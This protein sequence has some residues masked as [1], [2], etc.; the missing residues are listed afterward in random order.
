MIRNLL[1]IFLAVIATTQV[2][3]AQIIASEDFDYNNGSNLGGASGGTG[4]GAN[5]ELLLG[6][7]QNVTEDTIRNF[8]TGKASGSL[9]N[10][11]VAGAGENFRYQRALSSAITDNGQTIWIAYTLEMS[12]SGGNVTNLVLVNTAETGSTANNDGLKIVIGRLF[13]GNLGIGS[14]FG[15]NQVQGVSAEQANWLVA[16]ITFTGDGSND[17]FRLF[18]NPDPAVEPQDE[19]ADAT[20]VG[21]IL[22][23]GFDGILI[24]SET[25]PPTAGTL[26][27]IYI[28]NSYNDILPTTAVDINKYLPVR[29]QFE[30]TADA[31]ISGNGDATEGWGGPW[32]LTKAPEQNVANEQITN[33]NILRVT[34]GN[35]LVM[36]GA[37]GE[38]RLS[39][40]LGQTYED[41]GLTYWLSFMAD[42]ENADGNDIMHVM[43][44]NNDSETMGA[45]GPGGQFLAV[46]KWDTPF[47]F[48]LGKFSGGFNKSPDNVV[49]GMDGAHWFVVKVETN[50]TSDPDSV[51]LWLNPDPAAG[52][53]EGEEAVKYAVSTLNDGWQGIGIKNGNG[54]NRS[55]IDDIYLALDFVD[56]VPDDLAEFTLPTPAFEKFDYTAG[57]GVSTNG[58]AE[59]GWSGPWEL[60]SGPDQNVVAE[61]VTNSNILKITEGNSLLMDANVGETRI[62]RPLESTYE[63]N[64]LTYWMSFFADFRNADGNGVMNVMLT[65]DD[66]GAGGPNGQLLAVGKW[67]TPFEFGLGKFDGGFDKSPDNVVTGVDGS[68]W[69][70]VRIETNGTDAVDTVRLYLNPDPDVV[71]QVGD[72][73]VKY[74]ATRLNGGWNSIGIKNGT[75][76]LLSRIDD[77]YL[78][79]SFNEVVPGDL[80][81]VAIPDPAF[82][83][84][85]YTAGNGLEGNGGME[86]GWAGPWELL[87]GPSQIVSDQPVTNIEI[88]RETSGNSL[89]MDANVGESRLNRPL[90]STYEDNG[91]TYWMGFFANFTNADGNGV[92]NVML[93]NETFGAG[94]PNGQLLAVGKWDTP[95]EFGLG[96]FDGGF[97][98]SPENVVTGEDGTHWFVVR[99]E[100]NGTDAADTIRL[101]LNPD[102]GSEPQVGEE[103]VTYVATRLN[104]GWNGIG[105]KN[106]TDMLLA[107]IDDIY[108]GTSFSEIVPGDLTNISSLFEAGATYEPF[109]YTESTDLA[110]N[111]DRSEGF[112]GPWVNSSGD[113]VSL[114]AGS[115]ETDFAIFEGNKANV[116]YTDQP[117][118]YD[119]PLSGP[120]M[121]D[122]STIWMSFL[123]DFEDVQKISTEG[124]LVLMNGMEEVIGFGR[125]SGFNRIGF[126]W[127]PDVFQFI[128]NTSSDDEHWV[129]VRIDMS[130]DANAET[131]YMWIDPDPTVQPSA[132][133]ADLV[134]DEN[135]TQRLAINDGFDGIR[136]KTSGG[137][138]FQMFVDEIRLGFSFGDVSKLEEEIPADLVAREQFRY[139]PGDN[140]ENLGG[141]SSQWGGSWQIAPGGGGEARIDAGSLSAT[142]LSLNTV[143]EKARLIAEG[144]GNARFLRPLASPIADD[145]NGY[146]LSFLGRVDFAGGVVGQTG[147]AQDGTDLVIV[148]KK[149]NDATISILDRANGGGGT[150]LTD[151]AVADNNWH[152]IFVQFSGDEA[153]DSVYLWLNP[154]PETEPDLASADARMG[155]TSLNGGFNQI[156]MRTEGGIAEYFVDEIYFGSSFEAI[157][158]LGEG[159]DP[160]TS[161]ED[162][163]NNQFSVYNYPNPFTNATTIQYT[164]K[165]PGDVELTIMS[166]SGKRV[167]TLLEKDNLPGDHTISWDGRDGAGN[168]LP[169]GIYF[170]RL[171]QGD[172][173]V[174]KRMI[175]LNE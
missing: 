71:P 166:L 12:E 132:T 20:F 49:T 68:H 41:N 3:K 56:V 67:N 65:N 144:A 127:S 110:G 134:M 23:D 107:N 121:D 93:T 73:D 87:A 51:K 162:R 89:A 31:G 59:N 28:G 36:D 124:Q 63:D 57:A 155:T 126:T 156:F 48:G 94:G 22:N 38:T 80:I 169:T 69:F 103:D 32:E 146:W 50:G 149:F 10:F 99:I 168:R 9:L 97:N 45:S 39:R 175:L 55:R 150:A 117:V 116:N 159:G 96:K 161:L 35:T 40:P 120:F 114:D 60:L 108:L 62:R 139:D 27:D 13:N 83:K 91:L 164:L 61:S 128:S 143:G 133:R 75:D 6:P 25:D 118:N 101:Y 4:W 5:W 11:Q 85:D 129:V 123:I 158:P 135:S 29:E 157:A 147:F 77:I 115:I 16:K 138:P 86:N 64:G 100:T 105:I 70:V 78:G 141:T 90:T 76:M 165:K 19:D 170:Y 92:M 102:P 152:V 113:A 122:G 119:R 33:N 84:F 15:N 136:I 173:A 167:L 34:N 112:G 18:V 163:I 2:G 8:R 160:V 42:F 37:V 58:G 98:K 148:G 125:T 66:F 140:L 17:T 82:E 145:G 44:I 74:V 142:G 24:R 47:E 54:N 26:D 43:L 151:V 109:S 153:A 30:Y 171:V 137:T 130:G 131:I 72:E 154:D 21:G 88:L 79:N 106:G 52:P 14:P 111:G 81:D 172:A 7:E 104:N 1:I 95:F 53:Q 174:T 46:G